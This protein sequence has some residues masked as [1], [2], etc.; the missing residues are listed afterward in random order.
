MRRLGLWDTPFD[1]PVD[2]VSNLTALQAQEFPYAKW[3]VAQRTKDV[4]D[5][6]IER[7]F[8][9]GAI[10][11]T[12]LLRPTWHFVVS[13][14][15]RWIIDLTAPRVH[16]LNAYMYRQLDVGPKLLAK[17]N[18]LLQKNLAGARI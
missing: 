5:A 2:A 15:I 11:R 16:A 3:S 18:R 12:H 10:L 13:E 4:D 9:D 17:S 7:L 14:D 6:A 8:N 1:N